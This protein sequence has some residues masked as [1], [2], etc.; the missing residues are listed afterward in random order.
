MNTKHILIGRQDQIVLM[1]EKCISR[2]FL[3]DTDSVSY[4]KTCTEQ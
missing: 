2:L 3:V 4:A 1:I